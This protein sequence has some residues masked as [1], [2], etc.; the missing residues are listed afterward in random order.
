M[1]HNVPQ[2]LKYTEDHEW[3]LVNQETG[4]VGITDFA[5][6]SLG[7]IVYVELPTVGSQLLKGKA[8]GVVESIKSVSDLF[9]PVSG[10]VLEINENLRSEPDLINKNPYEAWIIKIKLNNLEVETKELLTAQDYEKFC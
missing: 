10:T 6:S 8:F 4:T 2:N 3:V 1:S 5:Q 7:D 9:A